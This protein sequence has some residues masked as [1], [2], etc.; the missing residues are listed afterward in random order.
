MSRSRPKVVA[1]VPAAG[2]G[3]RIGGDIKKQM[4]DFTKAMASKVYARS[5]G[6]E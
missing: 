1:I 5:Q 6:V 4:K 3:T 2:S